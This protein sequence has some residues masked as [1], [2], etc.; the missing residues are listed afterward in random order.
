MS[1]QRNRRAARAFGQL[2]KFAAWL[3]ALPNRLTP[4]PFRLMQLGSAYW[5]SRALHAAVRLDIAT[6]LGDAQLDAGD[7]AARIG[8]HP[9]ALLRLMRMLAA[10]GVF[11]ET[12]PGRF[13]N[14]ATST[15]LRSD[16]PANIRAL[17]LMHNAPEISAPWFEH[18]EQGIR[19]GETPFRLA[20]GRDLFE[21]MDADPAFDALFAAAMESVDALVGDSHATDFDWGCFR[22]VVDLGGS[23]GGKSLAILKH[24]PGLKALVVDRPQTI[25]AARDHWLGRQDAKVLD[26]MA[27]QAGDVLQAVPAAEAGDI[28]LLSAVLHGF[29]DTDCAAALR[30]VAAAASPARAPIAIMELVMP[31]SGADLACA[32]I[33]MQ[34]FVNSRGRERT[35]AQWRALSTEAGLELREVVDLRSMAKILV[36]ETA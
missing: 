19:S 16:N 11:A 6:A 2:L 7:I 3:Q 18:L 21:H 10:M 29:D 4:P 30:T 24:H 12:A 20:H 33:D 5:Q 36:L 14:T 13:A 1:L 23:K 9:D 27:F 31:E 28:F 34:L 8:A 17:I 15:C 25:A 26:R 22:R 35:L 32:A